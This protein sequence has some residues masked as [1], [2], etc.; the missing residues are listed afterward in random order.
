MTIL[1][2]R[3]SRVASLKYKKY[4]YQLEIVTPFVTVSTLVVVIGLVLRESIHVLILDAKRDVS[5]QDDPN[6]KLMLIFSVLNLLLDMINVFCFAQ[7]SH[8][9]GYKTDVIEDD[10]EENKADNS[11]ECNDHNDAHHHGKQDGS[12]LNM[13]SAWTHVMADTLRSLA[14][15]LAASLAR[16]VSVITAEVAD[17]SAAVVVSVIILLSLFPLL[18]GMVRTYFALQHVDKQLRRIERDEQG[19]S[20]YDDEGDDDERQQESVGLVEMQSSSSNKATV[21]FV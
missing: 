11:D 13:C 18:R 17:A 1:P 10:E 4:T 20:D 2:D 7:A 3:S 12:N 9:L 19:F 16:N 5:E 8:G 21:A 14:V 15:I 6:I